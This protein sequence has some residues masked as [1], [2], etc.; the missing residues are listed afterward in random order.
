MVINV[1]STRNYVSTLLVF[2]KTC[3][4]LKHMVSVAYLSTYYWDRFKISRL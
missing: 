1:T 4:S 2:G 3:L